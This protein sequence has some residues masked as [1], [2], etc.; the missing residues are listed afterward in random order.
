MEEY[1][2]LNDESLKAIASANML[3]SSSTSNTCVTNSTDC[4]N[5][6]EIHSRKLV[7]YGRLKESEAANDAT[8]VNV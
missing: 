2:E 7:L 8:C 5:F 6:S 4:T 1:K 3:E